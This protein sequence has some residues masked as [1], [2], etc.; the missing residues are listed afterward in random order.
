MSIFFSKVAILFCILSSNDDS[1]FCSTT[2]PTFFVVH[3]LDCDLSDRC[4]VV[5]IFKWCGTSLQ[6]L[7]FHLYIFFSEVYIKVF[8]PIFKVLL[9]SYFILRVV[10][11]FQ[12]TVLYQI[13]LLQIFFSKSVTCLSVFWHRLPRNTNFKI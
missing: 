6:I 8:W 12:I 4:V 7:I 9:L 5:L 1:S 10:G 11:I 2:L 13:C 3:V